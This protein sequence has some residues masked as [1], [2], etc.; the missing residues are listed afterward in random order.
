MSGRIRI[1]TQGWNYPAWVG[2]LYPHGT[3]AAGFLELYARA[4]GTVEIDS[5]F[6]ATPPASTVRGWAERVPDGFV[7]AL[8]LPREITH[9]RRLRG[10]QSQT[11]EFFDRARELGSRLGPVLV[12]LGPD[13]SPA[14]RPALEAFLPLLPDDVRVA[15]EFRQHAWITRDTLELLAHHGVA[16]ALTDGP[17]IP[18][19]AATALLARPTA[20]FHYL[21]WMGRNRELTDY[22]RVQL[23]RTPDLLAWAE[24]IAPLPAR[25]IDVFGYVNNQFAGHS[26]ATARELQQLLGEEPVDPAEI[27]DQITLF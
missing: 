4:F 24:Q 10:A 27:G 13:F 19:S 25:G 5:T 15:V 12:Q 9:E 20:A 8:K 7:F 22:S 1:G 11:A 17:W 16:L 26:P 21:R 6:Y 2:P 3:R 14:E 18:R 23:D